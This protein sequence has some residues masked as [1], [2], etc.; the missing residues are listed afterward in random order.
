MGVNVKN[1][2]EQGGEKTVIGGEII[3]KGKLVVDEGGSVEGLPEPE[4]VTLPKAANQAASTAST[5]AEL[6]ADFNALLE[7]LKAAGLMEA[8]AEEPEEDSEEEPET[9]VENQPE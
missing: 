1:Y 3:I 6:K 8:D 4:P 5:N 2:T 7:K 9:P